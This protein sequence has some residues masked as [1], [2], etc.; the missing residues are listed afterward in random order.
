M[1]QKPNFNLLINN[2]FVS[3]REFYSNIKH[4]DIVQSAFFTNKTVT[5]FEKNSLFLDLKSCIFPL[6]VAAPASKFG[7]L[8]LELTP[9]VIR[10]L[11]RSS[12]KLAPFLPFS[13]E[14]LGLMGSN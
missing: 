11:T 5:K 1:T 2:Q 4:F 6:K 8:D 10:L 3:Q 13:L 12:N 9:R 14:L 7:S